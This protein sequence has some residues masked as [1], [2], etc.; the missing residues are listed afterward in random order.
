MSRLRL[1]PNQALERTGR[2]W[3]DDGRGPRRRARGFSAT[4]GRAK[5]GNKMSSPHNVPPI[6][7]SRRQFSRWAAAAA[8]AGW[9]PMGLLTP[10]LLGAKERARIQGGAV[11]GQEVFTLLLFIVPVYVLC[12]VFA[13]FLAA[14]ALRLPKAGPDFVPAVW[15]VMAGISLLAIAVGVWLLATR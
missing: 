13:V 15:L 7:R 14:I 3:V 5:N 6:Q 10:V 9:V 2:R 12:Q 1:P 8:A 4:L 11:C